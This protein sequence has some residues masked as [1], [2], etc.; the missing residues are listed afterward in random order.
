MG[1]QLPLGNLTVGFLSV[2]S[3]YVIEKTLRILNL[4]RKLNII[5]A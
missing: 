2:W 1:K 4:F 5:R 3:R